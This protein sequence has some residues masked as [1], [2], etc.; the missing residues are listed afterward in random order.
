MNQMAQRDYIS[1]SLGIVLTVLA[2]LSFGAFSKILFQNW[3]HNEEFSYGLLIPPIVAYLIWK[4]KDKLRAALITSWTPGFLIAGLGCGL[5]ILA[6]RSGT[7]LLSGFALVFMLIGITGFLWGLNI[8]KICIGPLALLIMMVP[9]P[10]YAVGQVAWYLQ[11]VASTVSG[12]VLEFLGV[13]V[14]QDGNLLRLPNYVL[15]VKQACSGS[16]SIL[17][18]VA[19][20]LVIGLSG[21]EKLWRRVVLVLAAPVLAIVANVIRIVGTGL[22]ARQW[23]NLAANESLHASWGVAVF[24]LGVL[25]LLGINHLLRR[26]ACEIA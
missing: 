19:L 8:L 22:I 5:Q 17:S 3:I 23:G 24:L 6:S 14:Y 16:R 26:T 1:I 11:S 21:E 13:P 4:R 18:L 20:A 15:E 10:S 25:G 2:F 9:I 12:V 7:L